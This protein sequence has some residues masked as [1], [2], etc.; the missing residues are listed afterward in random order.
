MSEAIKILKQ[1]E[2]SVKTI[3]D[4]AENLHRPTCRSN[5]AWCLATSCSINSAYKSM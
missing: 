1:S 2:C 3:S 4:E 5:N